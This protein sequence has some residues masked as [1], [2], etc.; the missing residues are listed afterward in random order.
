M[1]YT[2][3]EIKKRQKRSERIKNIVS[4][5]AYCMLIP[6][7]AYNISLMIQA[8][9]VPNKTPSFFGIKTYVIISGSMEPEFKIGDIVI[10]KEVEE[11]SLKEGNIISFR[12]GQNV[13]THRITQIFEEEG[14]V[15][16]KTKGDNNNTEDTGTI[17]YEAIEGIM[18]GSI[19]F[20]G[21]VSLILQGK[22]TLVVIAVLVYVYFSHTSTV[23]RKK[24]RRK[25]KRM[26]YEENKTKGDNE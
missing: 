10:A 20:L 23:N 22:I 19:P 9:T 6:L 16:Y 26:K 4:I 14:K 18:I 1:L 24:N 21:K 7:L 15:K 12:Q 5:L 25:V 8:V 17:T 2:E 13:I 3:E 11:E